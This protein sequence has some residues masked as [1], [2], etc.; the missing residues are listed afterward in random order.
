[1]RVVLLPLKLMVFPARTLEERFGAETLDEK[2]K[3]IRFEHLSELFSYIA[4]AAGVFLSLLPYKYPFNRLV[5]YIVIATVVAFSIFWFRVLPKKYSGKFKNLIYYFLSVVFVGIVVYFTRGIQSPGIFLF[6]LSSLAV[7]ASMGV[8]ETTFFTGI[9]AVMIFFLA[10]VR[11]ENLSVIQSLSLAIL[12]V[13]G[14]ATIVILGW[15]VFEEEKKAREADQKIHVKRLK[16]MERI[17]DEFVFII[18]SKLAIPVITLREYLTT[19]LSEKFGILTQQQKDILIK[20]E[21]NSKRLELLV[22]DLLDLSK[23]ETGR[24]RLSLEKVD[25]GYILGLALSDFTTKAAE[26]KISLLYDNPQ[27]KIFVRGDSSR[28]HE[29]IANL[30]DNAIKY[31]LEGSTVKVRCYTEGNYAR[32]DVEDNGEGIPEEAKSH[33]FQKF[34][35]VISHESKAK[36]SGLGLFISKQLIDRQGGKIWFKS[37]AGVGTTFSFRLPRA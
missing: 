25:L 26:K 9:S 4:V 32:L 14:L 21:E 29:V 30:V 24:L 12:H 19:A 1:M 7:A 23:I 8:K 37:K 17:K 22:E 34:F 18:S 33:I 36:G 5:L 11:S 35:R 16:E 28:T 31:S 15:F 10:I 27:G 6:Y 20:T 3:F 2:S 13:W